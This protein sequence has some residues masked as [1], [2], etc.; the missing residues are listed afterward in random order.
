MFQTIIAAKYLPEVLESL[1]NKYMKEYYALF[2][3]AMAMYNYIT[4][5]QEFAFKL[6]LIILNSSLNN[7]NDILENIYSFLINKSINDLEVDLN[8]EEI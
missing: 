5:D 3:S 6:Y 7:V 2:I 1:E 8:A 4:I